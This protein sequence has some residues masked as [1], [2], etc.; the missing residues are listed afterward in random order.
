MDAP[1]TTLQN[2][3]PKRSWRRL[4]RRPYLVQWLILGVGILVVAALIAYGLY[5]DRSDMESG[6]RDRLRTQAHVINDNLG[7]QLEATD[8]ALLGIRRDIPKWNTGKRLLPD[9]TPRLKAL[10][11]AMPGVR[12]LVLIDAEGIIRASN[13]DA[14][15]GYD[16]H[17]REY[18]LQVR[19]HP[20][21]GIL[22]L[23]APYRTSLGIWSINISRM[24]PGLRGEFA[25]MVSA[26]LDPDY[27]KTLMAS[28]QYAPDMWAAVAH[29]DGII[30]MI[31]PE[32]EGQSGMNLAKPGSFFTRHMNSGSDDN[33][34]TGTVYA[35]GEERML[36][37]HTIHPKGLPMSS[38]LVIAI[39]RDLGILYAGW[40]REVRI[41]GGLFLVLAL[42]AIL[43]LIAYQTRAR[44]FDES[45][46]KA[47]A[48]VE[49][50]QAS[51]E[52]LLSSAGEGIYGVDLAGHTTF[53]NP[54]ALGMLGFDREEVLGQDQH[55]LFHPTHVDGSPNPHGDCPI[56][57]TLADGMRR[58]VEDHFI[59][60]GGETFPVHLTVTPILENGLRVGAAAVF[61]DITR[62][63]ETERELVRLATTDPL[64]GIAN[65]RRFI[66]QLEMEHARVRRFG[67]F[68]ALL[69]LDLDFFKRV[70][71]TY[72][73]AL[74][75][76]VLCHFAALAESHLRRVDLFGRLGGE[77]FG[78]LLPGTDLAG[79]TEFAERFRQHVADNPVPGDKEPVSY[80]V[81]IGVTEFDAQDSDPDSVLARADRA[82]YLA[83]ERGRNRV[84]QAGR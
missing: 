73:H 16:A 75:D 36:A 32:K 19:E 15:V 55:R 78:I 39:G 62:R 74:G 33:V 10:E 27:F 6:E 70:N 54:A 42:G 14:L 28:V 56:F 50:S 1:L 26:T 21:P 52:L 46:L 37:Q 31:V 81:S 83:K 82:L 47:Q 72:G 64:T 48:A 43:S 13:R 11:E 63:K 41:Q 53:I 57:L 58:E 66:E 9:I 51:F 79:A 49:K 18:F 3:D 25:G 30:I 29:G 61:Q 40:K 38:P 68:A 20:D 60:K 34:Y 23:S 71:D 44:R 2:Q 45:L 5:R 65:R 4:S 8:K 77:E 76:A 84:E 67:G 22:Y 59:R 17:Q 80:T 69:M 24:I 7:R 35:T 12:T